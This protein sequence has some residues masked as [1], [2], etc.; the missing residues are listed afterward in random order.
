MFIGS[1]L[2]VKDTVTYRQIRQVFQDHRR[3]RRRRRRRRRHYQ[4]QFK[5]MCK[6]CIFLF[7]DVLTNASFYSYLNVRSTNF[8]FFFSATCP[9]MSR[10]PPTAAE[11]NV[12]LIFYYSL[13]L[14]Q[15]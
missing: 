10:P 15:L 7:I 13:N 5:D 14:L 9:L 12:L 2:Y 6:V 1:R 11:R 4:R 3:H 8:L